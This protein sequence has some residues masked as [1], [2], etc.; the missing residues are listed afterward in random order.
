[1]NDLQPASAPAALA[2]AALVQ[3]LGAVACSE[4]SCSAASREPS[5]VARAEV[6]EPSVGSPHVEVEASPVRRGAAA[7]APAASSRSAPPAA[8]LPRRA[9]RAAGRPPPASP[10]RRAAPAPRAPGSPL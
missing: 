1:M 2:A 6:R 5:L 8:P 10:A 7:R 3:S 4:W 9:G